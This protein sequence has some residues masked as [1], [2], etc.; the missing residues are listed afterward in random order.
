MVEEEAS[1]D[2]SRPAGDAVTGPGPQ[3]LTFVTARAYV[4]LPVS[5]IPQNDPRS[6]DGEAGSGAQRGFAH[7]DT[8]IFD[9]DNTLYPHE[10]Q[11]WPQ[12]DARITLFLVELFGL[13]GLS[14]RALQ[15]HYYHRYG[16]TLRGLMAEHEVDPTDFLAFAHEIDLTLLDPD[17]LLSEAIARLPG[18][19]LILTNGSRQ[20]AENVCRKLGIREHFEDVFDIVAS[21]FVPKPEARAYELFLDRHGVDP[22]RSA[23]F[24]DIAHNLVVPHALGMTTTLVV[25]RTADPFREAFEQTPVIAPHIDHTTDELAAFLCRTR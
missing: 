12:V 2:V 17:A 3:G 7:V 6:T 23:I 15:K 8:W 10:A 11:L 13:D 20:H 21:G 19:K 14:A 25:P 24:E 16:T 5:S 22:A 4:C 18:R 9:L 1:C